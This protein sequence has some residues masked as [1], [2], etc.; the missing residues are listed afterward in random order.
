MFRH[1][2]IRIIL[3]FFLLLATLSLGGCSSGVGVGLSVGIP[4]G[5]HAYI[6]VG[7]GRWL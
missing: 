2:K 4:I 3:L 5:D 7:S 6:N 1:R